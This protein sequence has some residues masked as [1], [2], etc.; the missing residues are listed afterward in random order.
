[1]TIQHTPVVRLID[2]ETSPLIGYA[3]QTFDTNI[4]KTLEPSKVI[5][6]AWKDLNSETT[7]VKCL[8]DYK[9]YKPNILNDELLIKEAWKI[10][11][12]S[13]VLIANFGDAFDFKKLNARFIYYGLNAPSFYQTIDTKKAA[14]KYFKFDSNSLN[15]LGHYLGVGQKINNGG[16]ELWVECMA[17]DKDAWKRMAA[18]NC[19]DV[20]LLEQVYLKL[21]PFMATHPDLNQIAENGTE[22]ACSTCMSHN[23]QKRGFSLTKMGRKQRYQCS[24]CGSWS[25]GP[26]QKTA[27]VATDA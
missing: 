11:D 27:K 21:R 8:A 17:G 13:D 2:I 6:F 5:S 20:V 16:F 3:W 15:N 22:P 10:L 7:Y 25:T 1:L 24:D 12:E 18:Y 14:S 9:G 4:L 23:I 26:W 19:Q